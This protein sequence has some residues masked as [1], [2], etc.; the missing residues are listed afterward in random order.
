M[1]K[2]E[3]RFN[4]NRRDALERRNGKDRRTTSERLADERRDNDRRG[5]DRRSTERRKH[6]MHCG[7]P[8]RLEIKAIQACTCRVTALRGTP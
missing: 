4:Q 1:N 6:C 3:R 2:L 7:M 5:T 8:Y